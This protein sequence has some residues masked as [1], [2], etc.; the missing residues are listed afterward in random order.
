[1]AGMMPLTR[2]SVARQLAAAQGWEAK[3]RT[4]VQLARELPALPQALCVEE[5]RVSGCES[6]VWLVCNW[7]KDGLALEMASDSRVVQGLLAL[8][9]ACYNGRSQ[10]DVLDLDFEAWLGE[11]GLNRF[12]SASRGSGLR[13]IVARIRSCTE[14]IGI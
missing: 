9:Y 7:S 6:R 12:L 4:L 14:Q 1:M 2:E 13:A 10:Q 8:V 5:N 11:L 3:N